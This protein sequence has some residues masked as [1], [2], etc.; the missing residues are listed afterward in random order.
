MNL[1]QR[2]RTWLGGQSEAVILNAF[3]HPIDAVT[4]AVHSH[5]LDLAAAIVR[6][7]EARNPG[8]KLAIDEILQLV[9]DHMGAATEKV[10]DQLIGAI[11]DLPAGPT[12]VPVT[13]VDPKEVIAAPAGAAVATVTTSTKS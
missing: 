7:V 11:G 9:H 4:A 3:T 5:G 10:V 2:I 6:L 12:P 8:S 13:M 1:L